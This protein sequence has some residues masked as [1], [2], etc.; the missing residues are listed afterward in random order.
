MTIKRK[1]LV[2]IICAVVVLASISGVGAQEKTQK[3]NREAVTVQNGWVAGGPMAVT[4][5][6][7]GDNTFVYVSSEMSFDGKLVK[8]APY[9]AQGVTETVQTLADGNRIVR[10]STASIYRDSEGRTRREQTLNAVG[11]YAASADAPLTI[12]INDPVAQVNYILD[13]KSHTAR[14]VDLSGVR[15]VRKR[16][17]PETTTAKSQEASS[18]DAQ[19]AAEDLKVHIAK[20]EAEM[21]AA[22]GAGVSFE[23]SFTTKLDPK[24]TKK[25]SLGKQT[26]EGVE[27]EGTRFTTTIAAGEIGNEA[28]ISIV[29]ES[30]YSPE[31]QT[32]IMSKHSDP[33]VGENTY[34][35]TNINRSEPAHS[36]FE[37]PSDYTVKETESP[38][39]RYNIEKEIRKPGSER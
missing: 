22:G 3:F 28:P 23:R 38:M 39:M 8:G 15:V 14:K 4:V 11:V 27:A 16:T 18:P 21:A 35:L 9:S 26:I 32:V 1:N 19:K 17:A 25:E 13:A 7:Q 36:L 29:S 2:A 30:W 34:R 10:K 12:F 33:R 24:S 20:A 31:L 37:L 5:D 6:G